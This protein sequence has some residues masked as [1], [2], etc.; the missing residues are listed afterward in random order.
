VGVRLKLGP[1]PGVGE[2]LKFGPEP[3]VGVRDLD[4]IWPGGAFADDGIPDDGIPDDGIPDN[5]VPDDGVLD[6]GVA[7]GVPDDGVPDDA[8]PDDGVPDH[9]VAD[10]VPDDCGP[11]PACQG[12]PVGLDGRVGAPCDGRRCAPDAD[13]RRFVGGSKSW[14]FVGMLDVECAR[15]ERGGAPSS[16]AL[17]EASA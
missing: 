12:A 8:V 14:R 2:P 15:G 13:V 1:E 7:D 17:H 3:G 4:G 10:G 11:E 16:R 5:G 9:G 6:H